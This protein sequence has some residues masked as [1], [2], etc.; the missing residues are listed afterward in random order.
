MRLHGIFLK[1]KF[2]PKCENLDLDLVTCQLLS[3]QKNKNHSTLIYVIYCTFQILSVLPCTADHCYENTVMFCLDFKSPYLD[4][5]WSPHKVPVWK[6][7]GWELALLVFCVNRSFLRAKKQ[8]SDSLFFKE[9]IARFALLVRVTR[10]NR[11]HHSF[12]KCDKSSLLFFKEWQ[13]RI[14]FVPLFKSVTRAIHS[15]VLDI[16]RGKAGWKVK[17]WNWER[18]DLLLSAL[19]SFTFLERATRA[20]CSRCSLSK[21]RQEQKSKERK[22]NFPTLEKCHFAIKIYT[23]TALMCPK[24]APLILPSCS[25]HTVVYIL[26]HSLSWAY[27]Q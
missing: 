20:N 11:S 2:W 14:A 17:I 19:C 4:E 21:E 15:F 6:M 18:I 13:D 23:F 25:N 8:K 24:P 22:S 27:L 1:W 16:K 9:Q 5:M 10:A 7:Q 3:D 26:C 12:E